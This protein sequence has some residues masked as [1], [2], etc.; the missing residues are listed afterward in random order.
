[1]RFPAGRLPSHRPTYDL[2]QRGDAKGVFQLESEGIRELLKQMKPD[3]I[4]DLIAVLALYRP[5]PLGGGM[6]DSYVNRKHGREQW[7]DAHPVM[8]DVLNETY[9]VMVYQEQIMRILNRLGGIELSKSYACIKAISKKIQEKID[10]AKS[11]FLAGAQE[12][13]VSREVA[14][15]I[16]S[17]IVFF[18]G[19]GFNKCVVA[20]T[21]IVDADTGAPTT[22]GD[23]FHHRRPIRVHALG[24][25]GKLRPRRVTDVVWNGVKE[26]YRL[27][28][29][30]GHEILATANHPFRTLMGWTNLGE[31]QPGDRIAAPRQLT[32]PSQE[33]W[34][35][36]EVIT[37]AGL[38][39]ESNTCHPS[40]LYF[41]GNDPTLV[42]DFA[43]A[44]A[45]FPDT[46]ARITRRR[47]ARRLEVSANTG[48]DTRFQAGSSGG[49]ATKKCTRSG[50]FTWAQRLGILNRKATDKRVPT[51]VFRLCPENLQLFLGRLWAGDGFIA[52]ATLTTPFYAT[53][54]HGLARDVQHLLLRFGIV[55]RIHRKQFRY[56]GDFRPGFT[57]HLLGDLAAERFL[58]QIAPHC[59]GRETAVARLQEHVAHTQRGRTSKDTIPPEVRNQVDQERRNRGLT[60]KQVEEQSGVSM[61]EFTGTLSPTKTGFRRS[62][63]AQLA[64]FFESEA[65]TAIAHSDIFWDRVV[66]IEPLGTRDTFD[67]TVEDDHN[68]VANGLIVHNSH[69]AAYAQIGYQTA[70]LKTHYTAEFMAALLSSEVDDGNK[71]DVMVDHIADARKLGVAVEP[72][73]VNQG[74]PDF[75]VVKGKIIFGLTAIKGLGRSAAGEIVR[76]REAGK[77][78]RD[79]FDFCERVDPRIVKAAAIEKL[80]KAGAMDCFGKNKRAAMMHALPRAVEAAE[81]KAADKRRGQKNIF[82]IFDGSDADAGADTNPFGFREGLAEV[83]EWPE[84]EK[85]KLE[86]E[87]LDFY[88][89]SH[90][91]AQFDAQLRLFRTHDAVAIAKLSA[92][93]EVRIGGMVVEHIPK[94]VTKGRNQGNRW[95]IIRT[96]DFSG[97]VKCILWSDQYA[98]FKDLVTADAILLFAGKV[99]WREGS[100]EPDL[101]VDK[102]MTLDE[103]RSDLTKEMVIR[104][105][106]GEDDETYGKID[107][108]RVLLPNY[109]GQTPVW[110]VVRDP[111][112]KLARLRL[113]QDY[114]INPA[115]IRTEEL[116]T[117]LGA[118]CVLFNGR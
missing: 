16:F 26:V 111:A 67:L 93:T 24:K 58:E 81:Q 8:S 11:D 68:F 99:E 46:V 55:S 77:P 101:I 107:R 31:L 118:G 37:L 102:V 90:P 87:V 105:P 30:L 42:T 108:L 12:R 23:L 14:E 73:N 104:I 95:A 69:T 17:K 103:A 6:V 57:V 66:S 116:D 43:D 83:A 91:L 7:Q 79:L 80:I 75:D 84:L 82:D 71:R 9:G 40:T 49:L 53:S 27:T 51:A 4:R 29:E 56:R 20:E 59:L 48:Q 98:R 109:R 35:R 85:L 38:L 52:N 34:P 88:I 63:L 92:G 117:F 21:E 15:D 65:L 32:F 100:S 3:N 70:Y 64:T 41:Y 33:S 39:A 44:I 74:Q 18:A 112:G 36:H 19:Y 1:P 110:L 76:A 97:S 28:T 106:Y 62:T 10:S 61:Q 114:W 115:T 22:V 86:K 2:L 113:P 13:G 89:S 94:V 45:Q 25:D 5:G 78:F 50:A 96:E 47:D 54:S 72:P 60:W